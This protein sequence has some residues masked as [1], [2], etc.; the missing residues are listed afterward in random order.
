MSSYWDITDNKGADSLA[1]NGG[2]L[3]QLDKHIMTKLESWSKSNIKPRE[4]EGIQVI[5]WM[6]R[7]Y[8]QLD[9]EKQV[10]TLRFRVFHNRLR[11]HMPKIGTTYDWC[12]C[13]AA[14]IAAQRLL[15]DSCVHEGQHGRHQ[16]QPL[17]CC[18]SAAAFFRDSYLRVVRYLV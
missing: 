10:R 17:S 15:R 4:K 2:E 5:R 7:V 3:P 14:K 9:R 11:Y 1:R 13:D 12:T 8:H 16:Q 18:M 6:T